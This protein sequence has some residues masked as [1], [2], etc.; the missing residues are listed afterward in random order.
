M[1]IRNLIN[2]IRLFEFL[3]DLFSA[4]GITIEVNEFTA[5]FNWWKSSTTQKKNT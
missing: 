5:I 4:Q 1:R 3:T 2:F